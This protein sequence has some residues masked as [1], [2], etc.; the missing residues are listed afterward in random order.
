MWLHRNHW[1]APAFRRIWTWKSVVCEIT[2]VVLGINAN[3]SILSFSGPANSY[4]EFTGLFLGTTGC[5]VHGSTLAFVSQIWL[6]S[7]RSMWCL[8]DPGQNLQL[9]KDL[10]PEQVHSIN[11]GIS[12]SLI[13]PLAQFKASCCQE[14]LHQG[15]GCLTLRLPFK[16]KFLWLVLLIYCFPCKKCERQHQQHV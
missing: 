4:L 10:V 1:T 9:Y 7:L 15:L 14:I 5:W 11:E 16:F 8:E 3:M 12:K 2:S 6:L 13:L